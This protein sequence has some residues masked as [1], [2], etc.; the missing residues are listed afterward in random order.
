[1]INASLTATGVGKPAEVTDPF[2]SKKIIPNSAIVWEE[3]IRDT[4]RRFEARVE[5]T[6]LRTRI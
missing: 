6:E 5:L 4:R 2:F 1:M 3:L